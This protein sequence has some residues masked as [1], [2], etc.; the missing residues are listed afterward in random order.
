MCGQYQFTAGQCDGIRR[1]AQII[2]RKYGAGQWPSGEIHPAA[3]AP[4]L[5][6][7]RT[8]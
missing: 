5:I 8:G 2:D 3:K 1:I 4:V 7:H 6:Q